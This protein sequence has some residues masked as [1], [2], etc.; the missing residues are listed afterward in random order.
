MKAPRVHVRHGYGLESIVLVDGNP[1]EGVKSFAVE[2]TPAGGELVLHVDTRYIT[3]SATS[4]VAPARSVATAPAEVPRRNP[5]AP[6]PGLTEVVLAEMEERA[7]SYVEFDGTDLGSVLA[8]HDVPVLVAALRRERE[9]RALAEATVGRLR[10]ALEGVRA[11]LDGEDDSEGVPLTDG[12]A[13]YF[14]FPLQLTA[15]TISAVRNACAST[16][17]G[18][19]AACERGGPGAPH[20]GEPCTLTLD[21]AVAASRGAPA[22][23]RVADSVKPHCAIC[24]RDGPGAMHHGAPCP[25]TGD[26]GILDPGSLGR[27]I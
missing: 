24:E 5:D 23:S 15:R 10:E 9:A 21:P 2:H 26:P 18:D 16:K 13:D 7:R 25:R 6:W 11:H 12:Y 20:R 14:E 19:C 1:L 17:H 8:R 3:Q 22:V 27:R 4:S